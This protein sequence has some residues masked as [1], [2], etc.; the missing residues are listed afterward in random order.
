[1]RNVSTRFGSRIGLGV[2][3]LAVAGAG[4]VLAAPAATAAQ[5]LHASLPREACC[6]FGNNLQAGGNVAASLFETGDDWSRSSLIR[7]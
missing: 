1:M 5:G 6:L 7:S 2:A 4:S 3:A